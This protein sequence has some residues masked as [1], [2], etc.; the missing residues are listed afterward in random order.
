M[1]SG[2]G[3]GIIE[4]E[5]DTDDSKITR[6]SE[7]QKDSESN[8]TPPG[9]GL[10]RTP[11]R[12]FW[13]NDHPTP[14]VPPRPR[15]GP[16]NHHTPDPAPDSPPR[17]WT[18]N[19]TGIWITAITARKREFQRPSFSLGPPHMCCDPSATP[20]TPPLPVI[21]RYVSDLCAFETKSQNRSEP[22]GGPE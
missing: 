4:R 19:E 18:N 12:L 2:G 17:S 5:S 14:P 9:W 7:I 8:T 13:Y 6:D 3:S 11:P 22:L 1:G 20:Q 15:W 21:G 16:M 10:R